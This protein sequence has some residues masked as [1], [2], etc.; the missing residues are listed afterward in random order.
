MFVTPD[1]SEAVE[2]D[3]TPITG[4]YKGRITGCESRTSKAGAPML[5]W[6]FTLFG[7]SDDAAKNNNRKVW[8]NTM[9][10]GKGAG[11]LKSLLKAVD[12]P[13]A[14]GFDPETLYGKEV[15]LTLGVR[16]GPDGTQYQDVKAVTTIKH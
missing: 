13:T 3:N 14:G 5:N 16:V 11:A 10:S 1:F 9:T 15:Q 7:A 12:A 4:V 8:M 6:E 2:F